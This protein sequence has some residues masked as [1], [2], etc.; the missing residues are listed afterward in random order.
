VRF[1]R[2]ERS[3]SPE[4]AT[5]IAAAIERFAQDTAPVASAGG[6]ELDPWTRSALLEGVS[7]ED[8]ADVPHPWINT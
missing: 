5:A 3:P 8:H 2:I 7:R 6:S 1:T 4:E